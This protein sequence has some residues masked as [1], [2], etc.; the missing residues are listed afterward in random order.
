VIEGLRALRRGDETPLCWSEQYLRS[1]VPREKLLRAEFTLDEVASQVVEQIVS[2][3]L[4]DERMGN[5]LGSKVGDP[6]LVITRRHLDARGR[7]ISV[8]VHTHPAD[9]FSIVT[10]L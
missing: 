3:A 1:D 9:R 10:K 6:A 4:I 2:A 8:G 7:L 5:A